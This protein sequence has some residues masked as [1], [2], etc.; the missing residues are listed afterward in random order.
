MDRFNPSDP[1]SWATASYPRLSLNNKANNQRTSTYWLRDASIVRLKTAEIG[2][3]LPP[4]WVSGITM[5]KV[6]LY[7]S[8]YN[9]LTWSSTD[10]I[11]MEAR[12]SHY[13]VYP[14]QRIFNAG[15]NVTF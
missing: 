10:L 15:V 11:D 2:F 13:V 5:E 6:R 4:R 12:S 1:A 14:I 7:L 8:G 9:L 3:A